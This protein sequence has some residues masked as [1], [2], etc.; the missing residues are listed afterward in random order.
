MPTRPITPASCLRLAPPI[1][2]CAVVVVMA[3]IVVLRYSSEK[4][5][6]A[7]FCRISDKPAQSTPN[8]PRQPRF[9]PVG[10]TDLFTP[11]RSR[12]VRVRARSMPTDTHFEPHRH[13]WAQ[14]AYCA[15]GIVRVNAV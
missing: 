5:R 8:M 4:R 14:L 7:S 10:D 13:A 9:T 3:G 15:T 6:N 12:P 1:D 2:G 11:D